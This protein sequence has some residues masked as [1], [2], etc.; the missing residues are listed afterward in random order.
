MNFDPL[1]VDDRPQYNISQ[2]QE[3]Q[4]IINEKLDRL[5]RSRVQPVQQ[6]KSPVWDEIDSIVSGMSDQELEMLN[7]NEEFRESSAVVQGILQREYLRIMRPIVE[8]TQDGKDALD[9]H[10]TLIKRL[11]KYAKEEVNKKYSLIDEYIQ[12]HSNISFNEF[13]ETKSR[14]GGK[15]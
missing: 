15:K 9:R 5:N 14:K 3:E 12:H 11:R 7:Q 13:M 4:R 6:A 2:L 1:L 10:L 8:G